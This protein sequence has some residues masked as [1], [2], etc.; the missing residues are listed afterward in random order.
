MKK[1]L[2]PKEGQFYKANLHLHTTISDGSIDP[3]EIKRLYMEQ[4]YSIVAYSDHET[5]FP[6]PHLTDDNF[7][8]ITSTEISINQRRDRDFDFLKTY[9][10]H[11]L[12]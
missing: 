1:Y 3:K 8:A 7:L 2:L 5:L 12:I 9:H 11:E 6:H 4:G 10:L